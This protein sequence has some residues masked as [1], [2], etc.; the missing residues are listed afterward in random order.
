VRS[1][2]D[3]L[4]IA[5]NAPRAVLNINFWRII[6]FARIPPYNKDANENYV[7]LIRLGC[8]GHGNRRRSNSKLEQGCM[9]KVIEAEKLGFGY[10]GEPIFTN[11]GF[12]VYEG[13]YIAVIGS[14]GAGK[15][16]LIRLI[17]GE[18]S[19][20]EGGIRLFGEDVGR[21]RAWTRIGYVPQNAPRASQDFPASVKEIVE[22]NLYSQAGLFRLPGRTLRQK[23]VRALEQV[24]MEGYEKRLIG[25]LSGGQ[26]Q[27]VML[28][29]VLVNDPEIMLLDE[30]TTGVDAQTVQS[31]YELLSRLNRETGLTIMMVTHDIG[32]AA[33]YVSRILCLEEG[34]L[35]EL[36]KTQ[37][38]EELLHKHKH[39]ARGSQSQWEGDDRYGSNS[40]I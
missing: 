6:D 16:T 23:A 8:A 24:G 1:V 35:V 29:R 13:D 19:P 10:G 7:Q 22:A 4:N 33:N 12:T 14:N 17:L 20:S 37:V 9:Q 27:R 40:G 15:S 21:F 32:R 2:S 11:V 39:P 38:D 36:D 3:L 34:S 5:E 28:A 31:L 18:L 30:P 25:E 26:Q